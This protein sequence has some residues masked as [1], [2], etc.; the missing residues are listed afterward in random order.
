MNLE[1]QVLQDHV[2]ATIAPRKYP[3]SVIFV[4]A[5]P[6]TESGKINRIKQRVT[7]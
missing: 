3:R 1:N 5:L 7:S 2:N 6:K 4:G